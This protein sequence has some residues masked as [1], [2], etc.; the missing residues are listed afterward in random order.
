MAR[1]TSCAVLALCVLLSASQPVEKLSLPVLKQLPS[2]VLFRDHK[3]LVLECS[4]DDVGVK[5]TW[6]KDGKPFPDQQAKVERNEGTLV[7]KDPTK[8]DEGVY[9]CIA[10][11]SLG[12]AT[13]R[14]VHVKRAY[15][16]EPEVAV[17]EHS[18]VEGKTYK[19]DCKIPDSY[20]K[21]EIS[22]VLKTD[23]SKNNVRGERFTISDEGDLYISSVTKE[24]TGDTE[25]V[26]VAKSPATDSEVVLAK[27]VLKSVVP[28]KEVDHEMVQQY[29]T[30]DTTIKAGESVYLYCIYGGN[31]LAHPDWFKD[32]KDVNN[33]PKDRVTRHN[34][35]VG[36]RL[37]I[38]EVWLE[39]A[40][41]YSCSVD[42]EIGKVQKHSFH[43]KVVSAPK[44]I[45]KSEQKLV[46][47][48]GDDVTLPC[49]V[50]A[51]P[52]A[53]VSW[54][55]NGS[56]PSRTQPV[57]STQGNVVVSDFIIKNIQKSDQGYYGCRAENEYGDDYVETLLYVQ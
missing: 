8:A 2:E 25:Y 47:K 48:Q 30:K 49:H 17:K 6:Q 28:S 22:W 12:A 43:V 7:F 52:E 29:V 19:L 13:S 21:P 45:K 31:P 34:Q 26:C 14:P 1:I 33:G 41:E 54:T 5:Y 42:N 11:S 39:D 51:V 37:I 38:K 32:G 44:F 27:H 40:G 56:R 35:S 36:K 20:P 10:I 57:T 53:K 3:E 23:K 9:T 15:L 55:F 50:R 24:D 16:E 18:P 46:V 4:A